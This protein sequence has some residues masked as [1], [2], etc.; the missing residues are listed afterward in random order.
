MTGATGRTSF[1]CMSLERPVTPDPY[2][3][4]PATASFTVTSVD[5]TDIADRDQVQR[6]LRGVEGPADRG[7]CDVHDRRV[8]DDHQIAQAEDDQREPARPCVH[9]IA[10]LVLLAVVISRS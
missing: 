2:T 8:E 9:V 3:L 1:E 6:R 10:H 5:V 7:Q 4:L